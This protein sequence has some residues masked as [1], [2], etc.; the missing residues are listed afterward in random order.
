M[1]DLVCHNVIVVCHDSVL[2]FLT[3]L[4]SGTT[5]VTVVTCYCLVFGSIFVN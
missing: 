1:M 4:H 3:Q 2:I 5:V